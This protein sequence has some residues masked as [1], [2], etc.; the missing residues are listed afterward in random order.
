LVLQPP[1]INIGLLLI[2]RVDPGSSTGFCVFVLSRDD[3]EL[4]PF[5]WEVGDTE[6]VR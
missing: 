5:F 3:A 6:T 1:P 4:W 2:L